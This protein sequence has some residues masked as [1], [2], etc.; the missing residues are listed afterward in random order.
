MRPLLRDLG[1]R[2]DRAGAGLRVL[3]AFDVLMS[4][5]AGQDALVR[6]AAQLAGCVAGVR[7]RGRVRRSTP[8]GVLLPATAGS[9]DASETSG[10]GAARAGSAWLEREGAPG[11]TDV[12]IVERLFLAAAVLELRSDPSP[13]LE[14]VV[15]PHVPLAE[16]RT[17]LA[18][19]RLDP[20]RRLRAVATPPDQEAPAGPSAVVAT[21]FGLLRVTLEKETGHD[22]AWGP[23]ERAG[24]GTWRRADEAPESW[25]DAQVALRLGDGDDPVVDASTLG[26]LLLLARAE[27]AGSPHPDVGALAALDERS[28]RVLRVL[29]ETESMRAA[30]AALGMHHSSLQARAASLTERLGYD[31]RTTLGK[32]RF[33]AA[34]FL[35]RLHADDGD[36][37]GR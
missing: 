21:R 2:D 5:G 26:T 13:G 4:R 10:A 16:R 14:A 36:V 34:E 12:L 9:P 29:V 19:F 6:T 3:E 15:D 22:V 35:L 18:R 30:A 25:A 28:A 17:M 20:A 7:V 23:G 24:L 31:P 37:Q 8:D 11:E 1:G 27:E 33:A 32:L